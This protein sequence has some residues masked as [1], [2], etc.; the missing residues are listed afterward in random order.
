MKNLLKISFLLV[1]CLCVITP[2]S[3]QVLGVKGGLNLANMLEKDDQETYSDDFKS[4]LGFHV[5]VV[6]EFPIMDLLSVEP[7][8]LLDTKGMRYKQEESFMGET[9]KLTG[10]TNIF[11]L[12]IPINVKVSYGVG[13]VKVFGLVGPY[14]GIGLGGKVKAKEE[15]MGDSETETHSIDWGKDEDLKRPDF[16]MTFGAGAQMEVFELGISYALGMANICGTQEGGSV[17][18][19]RVFSISFAYRFEL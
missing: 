19:N 5:G 12:D 2:A 4:K 3:A 13:P 8:L 17:T 16:G 14:V 18:K 1:T 15:F 7:G 9:Y 11:Y 10:K 6:A